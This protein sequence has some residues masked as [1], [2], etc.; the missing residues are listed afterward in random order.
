MVYRLIL[1]KARLGGVNVLTESKSVWQ[2][3][4]SIEHEV[5]LRDDY[6]RVPNGC[7]NSKLLINGISKFLE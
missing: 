5:E 3:S 6:E 4:A 7:F 2:W 1:K